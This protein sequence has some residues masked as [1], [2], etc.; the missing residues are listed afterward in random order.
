MGKSSST[1]HCLQMGACGLHGCTLTDPFQGVP[2][3]SNLVL[4]VSFFSMQRHCLHSNHAAGRLIH[5]VGVVRNWGLARLN[6]IN[7]PVKS[8]SRGFHEISLVQISAHHSVFEEKARKKWKQGVWKKTSCCQVSIEHRHSRWQFKAKTKRNAL[9]TPA[10]FLHCMSPT[11]P[12][13]C[14]C[15]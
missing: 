11:F 2:R 10:F 5:D 15:D 1:L 4:S 8:F 3:H 12:F 13:D 7:F 14:C 9:R 6:F